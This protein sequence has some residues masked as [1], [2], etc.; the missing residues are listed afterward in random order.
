MGI[1]GAAVASV[2]S[3]VV[4]ALWILIFLCGKKPIVPIKHFKLYK[5]EIKPIIKLGVTNFIF[6]VTNSI[7]QAVVNITL[8]SFG[9]A[10]S[11]ERQ[12]SS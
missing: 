2:I 4:S 10:A 5:E 9:G 7:T 3:Q 12:E 6:R 1:A 8:K 11:K